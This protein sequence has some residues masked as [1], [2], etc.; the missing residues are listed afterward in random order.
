MIARLRRRHWRVSL[1]LAITL[2]I[3]YLI[4]LAVRRPPARMPELPAA[5][6]TPPPVEAAP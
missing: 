4:A 1:L 5:L 2:P 6:A 3:G